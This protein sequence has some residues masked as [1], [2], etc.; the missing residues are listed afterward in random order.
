MAFDFRAFFRFTTRLLSKIGD[1]AFGWTPRRVVVYVALYLFYP[2]FE[3]VTWF[4]LLLDN[5]F[6]RAYRR[7]E[8]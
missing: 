8:I 3:L 4:N 6:F 1:R 7:I 5:V 2:P